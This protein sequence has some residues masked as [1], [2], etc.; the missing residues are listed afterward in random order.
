ML[1]AVLPARKQGKDVPGEKVL[2]AAAFVTRGE[3][4]NS[5]ERLRAQL[6]KVE[7]AALE[8]APF[9]EPHVVMRTAPYLDARNLKGTRLLYHPL[10][11]VDA[12][13]AL[14][15]GGLPPRTPCK[16]LF[17]ASREVVPGLGIEGEFLAAQRAATLV[18]EI[19]K[20]HD[21]LK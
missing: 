2:C 18:Q 11:E 14:G 17:L 7:A 20:R 19:L 21:P 15:I 13:R 3:H 4:S 8:L 9:V 1:I 16:N 5:E 10:L 12:G 6:A